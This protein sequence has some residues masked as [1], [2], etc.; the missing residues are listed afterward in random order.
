MPRFR[1]EELVSSVLDVLPIT[2]TV[3]HHLA[4]TRPLVDALVRATYQATPIGRV[5]VIGPNDLLPQALMELGYE[6][7]LWVVD[8]FP[9]SDSNLRWASRQGPLDTI[10]EILPKHRADLVLVP[11]AAEAA[12]LEPAELLRTLRPHV[13]EGGYLVMACRQPGD[14]RRRLRKI[15]LKERSG[16]PLDDTFPPSPTWPALP[17]RRLL[18]GEDVVRASSG[19]FKVV[20]SQFVIDHRAYIT[21]EAMGLWRWL[22]KVGLHLAKVAVPRFRDCTLVTLTTIGE[23]PPGDAAA[24]VS[25]A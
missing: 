20:R 22:L 7:D 3:Y 5:L 15:L 13:R 11:Y 14:I 24:P 19:Q 16:T 1:V 21:T 18:T 23:A 25:P 10:I 6:V 12:S 2:D 9:L 4:F 17:A 8:G